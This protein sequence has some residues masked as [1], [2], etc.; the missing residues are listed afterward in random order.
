MGKPCTTEHFIKKATVIH[1]GLYCYS[2]AQYKTTFPPLVIICKV[3]G[4]FKQRP[5][6]HYAGQ[7]CRKCY[8]DS[9]KGWKALLEAFHLSLI[10]I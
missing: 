3:H 7:G 10:H 8:V 9:Q 1:G 2:E 5:H 4:K 6:D